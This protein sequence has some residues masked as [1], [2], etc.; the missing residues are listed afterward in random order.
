M[1]MVDYAIIGWVDEGRPADPALLAEMLGVSA[2]DAD[3]RISVLRVKGILSYQWASLFQHQR[4]L[5]WLNAPITQRR[6]RQ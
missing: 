5:N 4:R 1:D 3:K 2:D 6:T